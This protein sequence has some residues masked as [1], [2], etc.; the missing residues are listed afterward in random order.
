MLHLDSE[1]KWRATAARN[2]TQGAEGSSQ[3]AHLVDL[4]RRLKASMQDLVTTLE[5]E[6][7]P[8]KQPGMQNLI[9]REDLDPRATKVER[10]TLLSQSYSQ[11]VVS[12]TVRSFCA[13]CTAEALRA[14]M[15]KDPTLD[16]NDSDTLK[17]CFMWGEDVHSKGCGECGRRL[18]P[19]LETPTKYTELGSLQV[20][21]GKLRVCYPD[22]R[23]SYVELE[24]DRQHVAAKAASGET[25]QP[26]VETCCTTT[27]GSQVEEV[28]LK[29]MTSERAASR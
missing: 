29:H 19:N 4:R 17:S 7:E 22:S 21:A 6:L 24:A 25:A 9:T 28:F 8:Y 26:E 27:S 13:W 16:P 23:C 18:H 14:R 2:I 10:L 1:G 5:R 12:R 15:E 3:Q 11:P 20:C